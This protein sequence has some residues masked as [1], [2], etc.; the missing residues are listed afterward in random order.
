MDDDSNE[1]ANFLNSIKKPAPA[2][3]FANSTAGD[4]GAND[5]D[6]DDNSIAVFP[7]ISPPS[8]MQKLGAAK[9][10]IGVSNSSGHKSR[11]SILERTQKMEMETEK[12]RKDAEETEKS[13]R[14][15]M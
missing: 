5:D 11:G 6:G 10:P 8:M 12:L 13:V 4:N 9:T 14:S 2:L 7:V 3:R 1:T 15:W